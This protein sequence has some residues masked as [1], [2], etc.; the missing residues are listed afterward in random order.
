ANTGSVG[1][2]GTFD[3]PLRDILYVFKT[4]G[5]EVWHKDL[6]PGNLNTFYPPPAAFDFDGDGAAELV[7]QDMQYLYVLDGRTGATRFQF[8]INNNFLLLPTESPTIADV[9][10]DGGAEIVAFAS[11]GLLAGAPQ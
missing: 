2:I 1:I 11:P 3:D 10:N 8:A 5:T 4:D 7:T 9:D 6:T